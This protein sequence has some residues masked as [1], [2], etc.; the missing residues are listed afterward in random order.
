MN[1]A[2]VTP[3]KPQIVKIAYI[4]S[5]QADLILSG[6][7]T[8][9]FEGDNDPSHLMWFIC[10][11]SSGLRLIAFADNEPKMWFSEDEETW[12]VL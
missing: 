2:T 8:A 4:N 9:E 6:P 10:S 1:T 3:S 5:I 7:T 12:L 11:T